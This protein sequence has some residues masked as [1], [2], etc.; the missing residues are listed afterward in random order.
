MS[1]TKKNIAIAFG[2]I[3][4][5]FLMIQ[6]NPSYGGTISSA[7]KAF[8]NCDPE[9]LKLKDPGE[10]VLLTGGAGFI[11]MHTA[12]KLKSLGY[13]VI[14][15]D[16]MNDYYSTQL[17][18]DRVSVLADND[19][20]FVQGDVCDAKLVTSL[21]KEHKID[22]VIHLAAQAGVTYSLTNPL[23]YTKNNVECFVTLMEIYVKEGLT[24]K[25]FV[26]ASSSSVYGFN[27]DT[28]F[29][30]VTSEVDKPAS[31]YAATKR[32]DELIAHTYKS[33][34]KV[35][36]VGLRFFTV[37][38]PWGRPDMAPMIFAHRIDAEATLELTNFGKS[39]RDFTYVDDIVNGVIASFEYNSDS[40]EVFNLGGGNPV[41]L[42][43]FVKLMEEGLHKTANKNLVPIRKGD[44]PI[45]TADVSKAYCYL[46]WKPVVKIEEGIT[47]F[48]D[49]FDKNNGSKYMPSLKIE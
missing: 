2:I 11:G 48:L 8:K 33:L 45:T 6:R 4:F 12:V 36:S 24:D 10:N 21:I 29:S 46:G 34:Y 16:N 25:P 9:S 41:N 39:I 14:V 49:W 13:N 35:N 26:Y 22:R 42:E 47:N 27:E 20:T 23:S 43:Y 5:V 1:Y 30:E 40:A 32:S 15:I 44:V 19:V 38:G 17:K 31:L 37:Y 7:K 28:K 3:T 18:E